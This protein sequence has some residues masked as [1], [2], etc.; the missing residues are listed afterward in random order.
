MLDERV[1]R[2]AD[3][4][5]DDETPTRNDVMYLLRFDPY[6]VEASYVCA[7]AREVGMRACEGRGYV[8]AQ[9]GVDSTPCAKNCRFCSFAAV[10]T[11]PEEC[12]S[13]CA[14][15]PIE[16]IVHF[17]K[18][19]DDS[20]ISLVSLMATA[21]LDFER[22]LEIIRAVRADV[23]D[24]LTIMANTGDLTL[25]QARALK[26]AGVTAAYHALRLGEGELTDIAPVERRR[27]IERIHEAGMLVMTGV[28][29]L[30]Q[31]VGH[32]ELSERIYEIPNFHPFCMGVC[33]L[34][35]VEGADMGSHHPALTGF[36][37]YVAAITRLVCGQG[38]PIGGIGGI[39]WVDAGCDPRKREYGSSDTHLRSQ[40]A[41]ATRELQ[42][43]GFKVETMCHLP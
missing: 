33:N 25:N 22:Y 5:L 38:V 16:R 4:A 37:R 3:K 7:R 39:R 28:E 21:Q 1:M 2:I 9:I 34:T 12:D 18:L 43:E 13:H 8:Y 17:A 19:F 31:D 15:V 30:W 23:S 6:S 40:I 42:S 10:N 11:K 29:P 24:N 32:L 14:Q 35:A 36:V 20:G 27:T 41:R 26:E